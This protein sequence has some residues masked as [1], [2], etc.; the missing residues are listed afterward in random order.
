MK[1]HVV[2]KGETLWKIAQ[3]YGVDFEE[4]K[5]MNTQLSNP[6]MIM[7][8][9]KIKIPTNSKQVK[10]EQ[11]LD[12]EMKKYPA[13]HMKSETTKPKK[14]EQSKKKTEAKHPFKDTSDKAMPVI[15]EDDYK[16]PKKDKQ[17]YS[18]KPVDIPEIPMME[19]H[20]ENYPASV[21]MPKMPH[22]EK[23]KV[24]QE[25]N[26]TDVDVDVDYYQNTMNYPAQ[27]VMPTQQTQQPYYSPQQPVM[28]MNYHQTA[29]YCVPMNPVP[30][31][32]QQAPQ[33][34]QAPPM[35][36]HNMPYNMECNDSSYYAEQTSH[37]Q[38]PI[39][40]TMPFNQETLMESSSSS[41]EMPQMPHHLAG[42]CEEEQQHHQHHQMHNKNYYPGMN[43]SVNM[44][45][46]SAYGQGSVPTPSYAGGYT[47]ITPSY[48]PEKQYQQGYTQN[49]PVPQMPYP[50]AQQGMYPQAQY[51]TSPNMMPEY[52]QGYPQTMSGYGYPQQGQMMPGYG[53]PTN[54]NQENEDESE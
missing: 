17:S 12:K 23:T 49:Q 54:R 31:P 29:P 20:L 28:P 10:K 50:T 52:T 11:P 1:I 4:V 33:M 35:P 53:Y 13:P 48:G 5:Q 26:K 43:H 46:T 15:K 25:V 38:A 3:K 7:P 51:P 2:Q 39:Q 24:E 42:V 22:F 45:M 37:Y 36:M 8:G 44:P 41:L 34:H 21:N 27:P 19:Q 32:V 6:D 30:Y 16:K 40:S 18:M 9:M 14:Q 47:P